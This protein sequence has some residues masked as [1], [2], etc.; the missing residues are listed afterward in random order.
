M[1]PLKAPFLSPLTIETASSQNSSD[2]SQTPEASVGGLM[3]AEAFF[4][5]ILE[6]VCWCGGG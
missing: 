5:F 2:V 3:T 6:I 4:W 1:S